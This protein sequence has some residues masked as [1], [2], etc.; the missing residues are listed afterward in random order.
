MSTNTNRIIKVCYTPSHYMDLSKQISWKKPKMFF[1]FH[2]IKKILVSFFARR[3]Q[4]ETQKINFLLQL[5]FPFLPFTLFTPFF[6]LESSSSVF[7]AFLKEKN[8]HSC[9]F[10]TIACFEDFPGNFLK[11]FIVLSI[12]FYNF[13][14]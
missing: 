4:Q 12:V 8:I 7:N 6:S 14:A 5:F 3:K 9:T 11:I 2:S 10:F 1:L 13:F